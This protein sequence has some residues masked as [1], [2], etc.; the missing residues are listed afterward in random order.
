MRKT[1][2]V[3]ALVAVAFALGFAHPLE[4]RERIVRIFVNGREVPCDP[5]AFIKEGRTFVPVRFVSEAL[6]ANVQWDEN[7]F[8][9]HVGWPSWY[10]SPTELVS[11]R[12]LA[13]MPGITGGTV[14]ENHSFFLQRGSTV[15]RF[16]PPVK[17]KAEVVVNGVIQDWIDVYWLPNATCFRRSDLERLGILPRER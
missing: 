13:D 15:I 8:A 17:A 5:P 4:A 16:Y 2:A 11:I 6:G 14:T 3:L 1:V 9:V 12:E 7:Q 10:I